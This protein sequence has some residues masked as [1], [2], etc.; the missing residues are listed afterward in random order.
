MP[1]P[2]S[3]GSWRLPR[4][5]GNAECG[6]EQATEEDEGALD[7][8]EA[9]RQLLRGLREGLASLQMQQ[10][11]LVQRF[12]ERLRQQCPR[13][14]GGG[15]PEVELRQASD[16]SLGRRER[17]EPVSRQGSMDESASSTVVHELG[18]KFTF[19]YHAEKKG[20]VIRNSERSMSSSRLSRL[21]SGNRFVRWAWKLHYFVS[22]IRQP[23]PQGWLARIVCSNWFEA[24]TLTM[25]MI[26]GGLV[27]YQANHTALAAVQDPESLQSSS[28]WSRWDYVLENIFSA[29]FTIEVATRIY[30]HRQY[31]FVNADWYWNAFDLLTIAVTIPEMAMTLAGVSSGTM[32]VNFVRV[33]RVFRMTRSL[34][35]FRALHMVRDLRRL[36]EC[37]AASMSEV[38][39]CI[40]LIVFVSVIFGTFLC[41]S[42]TTFLLDTG[43]SND[44]DAEVGKLISNF[45]SV[46]SAMFTLF[47]A[48]SGGNDWGEYFDIVANVGVV[49]SIIFVIYVLFFLIA[50][51]N[52]VTSLFIEKALDIAQPDME[53]QLLLKRRQD[54]RDSEDLM[55]LMT[56]M[57]DDHSGTI[58]LL[59]FKR[60]MLMP[61]ILAF[62]ELRN[63]D[64][65]DAEMVFHML[66]TATGSQ[67][68]ELKTV[69]T[70]LM[71]LRGMAMNIDLQTLQFQMQVQ[72]DVFDKRLLDIRDQLGSI[73]SVLSPNGSPAPQPDHQ[74]QPRPEP[75]AAPF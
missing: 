38:F 25:V 3:L 42:V 45:G 36:L 27:V 22:D 49:A 71:H 59:E 62:F 58:S 65:K 4:S 56:A 1:V 68:I 34:R 30:V 54:L 67:E 74:L 73:A 57:D 32:D 21:E 12:A 66:E 16:T 11:R 23:P 70:G 48:T 40:V 72:K 43:I 26:N 64:I 39:W 5:L 20:E 52:I 13:E 61:R 75:S 63:I 19:T 29:Y 41:Q 17:Q 6:L 24:L 28:S 31:F 46:P 9:E 35:M 10:E 55:R 50:A 37:I 18:R 47:K 14:G 60:V 8:G 51:W 15:A 7:A 69:V 44:Q 2:T 33:I 53:R